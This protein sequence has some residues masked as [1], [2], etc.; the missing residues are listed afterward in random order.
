MTLTNVV[1]PEYC[2]PTSVSSISSFQKRL[3]NQSRIRLIIANMFIARVCACVPSPPM[4]FQM[5]AIDFFLCVSS[6]SRFFVRIFCSSIACNV[7]HVI[8]ALG[9]RH[10]ETDTHNNRWWFFFAVQIFFA[11]TTNNKYMKPRNRRCDSFGNDR[12]MN[13]T[14]LKDVIERMQRPRQQ[15]THKIRNYNPNGFTMEKYLS[16]K[17]VCPISMRNEL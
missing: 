9:T 1:L 4:T 14:K 16:A 8:F 13:K 6:N 17:F 15:C 11:L 7:N 10:T 3:L 12:E 2:S 5:V